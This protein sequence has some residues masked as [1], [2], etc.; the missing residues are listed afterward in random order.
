MLSLVGSDTWDQELKGG[1][2]DKIFKLIFRVS[3][4][5]NLAGVS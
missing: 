5:F 3:Q 4:Y 1:K 2:E